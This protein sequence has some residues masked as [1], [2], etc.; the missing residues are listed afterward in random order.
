MTPE[1]WVAMIRCPT[2]GEHNHTQCIANALRDVAAVENEACAKVA[3][4]SRHGCCECCNNHAQED[5]AAEIRARGD[6]TFVL[7]DGRTITGLPD[8]GGRIGP[9][10]PPY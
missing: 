6:V 10:A 3:E 7:A 5:I 1:E 8:D 9:A 4:A 2:T